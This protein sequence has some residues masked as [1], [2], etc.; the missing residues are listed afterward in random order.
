MVEKDQNFHLVVAARK[1]MS[2]MDAEQLTQ[3]TRH[4]T[5]QILA[6]PSLESALTMGHSKRIN[7]LR[8]CPFSKF[9]G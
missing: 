8:L 3:F 1:K 9:F 2:T 4:G 5:I 7:L 6:L